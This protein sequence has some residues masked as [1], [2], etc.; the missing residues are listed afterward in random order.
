[1]KNPGLIQFE[2]ILKEKVWGGRRLARLGKSLPDDVEVGES[3]EIADLS[4]TSASGGGGDA[5][6]SV[7]RG[8]V[9]DGATLHSLLESHASDLLGDRAGAFDG[10]FPLLIKFLDARENLSVQA[11]PS[12]GYASRHPE[13]HLKTESWFVVEAEPEALIYKG[14]REGLDPDALGKHIKA[15]TVV[16]DLVAIPVRP[17]DCFNLP[18]GEVHALGE[19]VLV[20][21]VQTPS[22]TTFRVFDWGRTNRELHIDQ[23]MQ[24][25]DFAN[26]CSGVEPSRHDA[27]GRASLI[28]TE[29]FQIDQ[30]N[31]EAGSSIEVHTEGGPVV[32]MPI[33]GCAALSADEHPVVSAPAGATTLVPACVGTVECRASDDD[34]WTALIITIPS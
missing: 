2:P 25:I 34:A 1:M 30:V 28:S 12:P 31:L 17:G 32:L 11:H 16:E 5:A 7:I 22:D 27:S 3:W 20:A 6:H 19:G 8:G 15:G 14:L 26:P 29:F 24:C 4:E 10:S 13:A 21:E 18:S 9:F 33:S 23:A